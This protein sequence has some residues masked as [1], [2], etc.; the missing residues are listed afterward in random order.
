MWCCVRNA[1][2]SALRVWVSCFEWAHNKADLGT[3]FIIVMNPLFGL[4]K[5]Y[6]GLCSW[7]RISWRV[8]CKRTMHVNTIY[9]AKDLAL[10]RRFSWHSWECPLTLFSCPPNPRQTASVW[11]CKRGQCVRRRRRFSWAS[12]AE[13][14]ENQRHLL[15]KGTWG[16]ECTERE[17]ACV[18]IGSVGS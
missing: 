9:R 5:Q 8:Q 2:A 1:S 6:T 10:E 3:T 16:L 17:T 7:G 18:W 14:H 4:C 13:G 11:V 12:A 15:I